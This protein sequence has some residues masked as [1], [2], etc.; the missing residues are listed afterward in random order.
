MK[1]Q[2]LILIYNPFSGNGQYVDEIKAATLYFR[3]QNIE[4]HVFATT[5]KDDAFDIVTKFGSNYDLVVC[6]G[7]DGTINEVTSAVMLLKNR[8]TIGYIPTGTVNDFG[9]SLNLTKNVM[10][11]AKTMLSGVEFACDIGSFNDKTF[12]YIAAFGL[13][14]DVSYQTPQPLKNALGRIAYIL[15][16]AKRLINI[17]SY[18]MKI[19]TEN[20][21]ISGDF[22]YGMVTNSTSVGGFKDFV[23]KNVELDD[24]LFEI[25]LVK[26]PK[27]P[28]EVSALL[29]YVLTPTQNPDFVYN[30]QAK[31]IEIS[32]SE[33]VPWTIDGEFG[34]DFDKV[35]IE[36][37][38]KALKFMVDKRG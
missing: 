15:E 37:N 12:N 5:K 31:K 27:N 28:A 13:F 4:V 3:E 26:T 14:T 2:R 33:N 7:G 24:G 25:M 38:Q 23:G 9:S 20:T 21:T 1:H 22:M 6:A 35:I 10:T 8:P 32:A 11:D 34:G 29:Q 30:F 17:P 36:N 19:T 18:K 16:G